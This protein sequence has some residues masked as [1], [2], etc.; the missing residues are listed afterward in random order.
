MHKQLGSH[1]KNFR[2]E[3]GEI[4]K[5]TRFIMEPKGYYFIFGDAL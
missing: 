2:F 3:K 5:I 4:A 1:V